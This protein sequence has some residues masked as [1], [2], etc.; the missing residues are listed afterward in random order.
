MFLKFISRGLTDNMS[1]FGEALSQFTDIYMQ[2]LD[3]I[4]KWIDKCKVASI[5]NENTFEICYL[6]N[7]WKSVRSLQL[8]WK[9]AAY[10]QKYVELIIDQSK[11][12]LSLVPHESVLW[13]LMGQGSG[14]SKDLLRAQCISHISIT[15]HR[16]KYGFRDIISYYGMVYVLVK[17]GLKIDTVI[18]F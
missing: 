1:A 15:G 12:K 18:G 8:F 5:F 13:P 7:T 4:F 9:Y 16:G 6:K 11:L 10:Q 2:W 14:C 3:S 17:K